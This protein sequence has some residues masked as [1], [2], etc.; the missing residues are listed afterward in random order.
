MLNNKSKSTEIALPINLMDVVEEYNKKVK[1]SEK[2]VE[3]FKASQQELQSASTIFGKFGNTYLDLGSVYSR[4]IEESLK[5]SAWLYV[6]DKLNLKTI[7]TAK[8]QSEFERAMA[9]PPEF[10]YENVLATFGDYVLNPFDNIVRGLAEVFCDLDPAYKSHSKVKIGVEGLPKRV[11]I[12]NCS[13]WYGYGADRLKAILNALAAY[14][15][16]PLVCGNA[17]KDLWNNSEVF[18]DSRGVWIKKFKNGNVHMFFDKSTLKDIN[19]ALAHYYGD[20][21]PDCYDDGSVVKKQ[22]STEVAK[23]LQYYPT[24]MK[25]AERLAENFFNIKGD[26]VL[27]PSCGDG[28]ILDAIKAAGG[29]GFGI[30]VDPERAE[31]SRRKGHNVLTKNFLEVVPSPDYDFVIM[32]P[33]FY[34]RHYVKHI[35]HALK[36]LKVGGALCSVLPITA[37]YDHCDLDYLNGQ[38]QDLP[39][40]SFR[41]SGTNIN[42]TVFTIRK[43]S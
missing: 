39:L 19:K 25:V 8:D 21:L 32:N 33:P 30:E 24:P 17:I 1:N 4:T 37:R 40:G 27:E 43:R 9:A 6:Y 10:T 34:G 35:E 18:K 38:W 26:K 16:K 2:A 3:A 42:T 11:V 13:S 23:D 20:V 14:Q 12:N 22:G 28:R 31:Q 15:Q 36:F 29:I 7:A 5:K 41:E